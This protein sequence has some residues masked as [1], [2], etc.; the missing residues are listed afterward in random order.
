MTKN[1][2]PSVN[3]PKV[4]EKIQKKY[5]AS[6]ARYNEAMKQKFYIEAIALT[7]SIICD[8][9]EVMI[10]HLCPTKKMEYQTIG[11]LVSFVKP[12]CASSAT[13]ITVLDEI[14]EWSQERNHA[15][16][17]MAKIQ[18]ID[19]DKIFAQS[20]KELRKT[21]QNGLKLFRKLDK[22][23]EAYKKTIKLP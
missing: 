10:Q 1:D 12:H 4:R 11:K 14:K 9:L 8:R 23:F 18:P 13:L 21:A 15:I 5:A 3:N 17:E 16:H 22:E 20:Y 6:I 7:E 2:R 19:M